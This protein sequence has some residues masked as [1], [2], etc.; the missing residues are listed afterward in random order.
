MPRHARHAPGEIVYHVLNRAAGRTE[1][2]RDDP[3]YAAFIRVLAE[4][5]ER[6]PIRL[7]GYCLMP[8]HWHLVLWP[9]ADGELARFMQRLTITH[10]RRWLE[11]RHRVGMGSVYQGR[12]KSFPVQD[13]GHFTSLIR[14]VERNPLRAGLVRRAERWRWSSASAVRT[15]QVPRIEI[16]R[17][18]VSR[19]ADW[20]AWVNQPQ[21]AAE[22]Q[23]VRR[24]MTYSRPLGSPA[25]VGRMEKR[26]EL[27]PLRP[28]GRPRKGD[29]K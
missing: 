10:V 24:S 12:Y 27:P 28:R 1:L 9:G 23:A 8:N 11:H 25:W 15:P 18:P 2:F 7:C 4:T 13:D 3:D 5:V 19:R 29:G 21:T 16:S 22:E 20:V 6:I 17:G 26:L 14:Y